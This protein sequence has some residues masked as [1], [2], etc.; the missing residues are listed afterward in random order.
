MSFITNQFWISLYMQDIQM[1]PPLLIA[2]RLL[3]Q[4]IT[5]ILWSYFGQ[6]LVS[7]VRGTYIM[8]AGALAY[9]GGATL[10]IFIRENTS[11]WR[12]LF[13]SLCITVM[14][15]DFQFIVANVSLQSLLFFLAPNIMLISSPAIHQYSNARSILSRCR[16][17]SNR[18]APFHLPRPRN[19][20]SSL[21]NHVPYPERHV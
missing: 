11:Y 7:R 1:F 10:L 9:V 8:G 2:A 19:H 6:W 18:Y 14:G 3:P 12:L 15:A 16:C 20:S 4:T 21:R 17:P 13:P 5:G